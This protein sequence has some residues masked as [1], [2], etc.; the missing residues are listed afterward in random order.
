MG[1]VMAAVLILRPTGLT[2]GREFGL[3]RW[4]R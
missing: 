1:A 3:P 2:G 4:R